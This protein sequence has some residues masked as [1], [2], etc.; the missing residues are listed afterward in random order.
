[1]WAVT[2]DIETGEY[3]GL[4]D[5]V[6]VD[7]PFRELFLGGQFA[8]DRFSLD[9]LPESLDTLYDRIYDFYLTEDSLGVITGA[10]RAAGS[11]LTFEIPYTDIGDLLQDSFKYLIAV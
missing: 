9:E 8:P 7:E 2:V 5:V 11:Y 10:S 3:L 1:M 6:E 4:E